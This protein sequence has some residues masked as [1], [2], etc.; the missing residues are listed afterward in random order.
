MSYLSTRLAALGLLVVTLLVGAGLAAMGLPIAVAVTL[1]LLIVAVGVGAVE[2]RL[3][4]EA[5]VLG[6][7]M[8]SLSALSGMVATITAVPWV[9]PWIV[10]SATVLVELGLIVGALLLYRRTLTAAGV[11][12]RRRMA[13]RRGWRYEPEASVPVPGPASVPRLK[14]VPTG[15]TATTGRDVVHAT[16]NGLPVTVFD[17]SDA[18]G[19]EKQTVWLV[20]L[21]PAPPDALVA[22]GRGLPAQAAAWRLPPGAWVDGPFLCLARAGGGRGA[23]ATVVE[24]YVDSLSR[25]AAAFSWPT[26]PVPQQLESRYL[27]SPGR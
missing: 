24:G 21:P 17:R 12:A 2:R 13:H 16:A 5:P 20:H 11:M 18:R 4:R 1:A 9:N 10:G 6:I 27:S 14:G 15:A 8:L 26:R 23:K 22:F 19:R 25:F 7:A 3:A